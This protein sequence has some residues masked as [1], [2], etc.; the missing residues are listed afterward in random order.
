VAD[1]SPLTPL[2]HTLRDLTSWLRSEGWE[3]LVIG[4]VA[5]SI[6]GRPRTTRDVDAVIWLESGDFDS[7]IESARA[8]GFVPR[9][10]DA[11]GFARRSNVILLRH[12]E[13]SIDLDLSVGAL[14]FEREAIRRKVLRTVADVTIPIPTAEDLVVMKAIAHR[15]R[16][17]ADIEAIV[18]A[19]P[20]LDRDYVR[21]HVREFATLLEAPELSADLEKIL[22][23]AKR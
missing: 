20:S 2:V 7:V 4:G 21:R 13:T 23:R 9:I 18:D 11:I 5:A 19:N 10:E 22:A 3:G 8:H 6:L 16:D 15:P 1:S 14:P 17:A 12:S